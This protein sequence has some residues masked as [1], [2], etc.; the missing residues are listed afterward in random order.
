MVLDAFFVILG[1]VLE[2]SRLA[3]VDGRSLLEG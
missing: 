1:E 3:G 2:E